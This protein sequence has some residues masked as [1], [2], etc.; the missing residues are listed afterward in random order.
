MLQSVQFHINL[1]LVLGLTLYALN[2]PITPTLVSLA[3]FLGLSCFGSILITACSLH[4]SQVSSDSIWQLRIGSF[5]AGGTFAILSWELSIAVGLAGYVGTGL[6]ILGT[7]SVSIARKKPTQRLLGDANEASFG[8]QEFVALTVLSLL[9]F[10]AAVPDLRSWL[11]PLAVVNMVARFL[12]RLANPAM[13]FALL[14]TVFVVR[15]ATTDPSILVFTDDSVWAEGFSA[16]VQQTGFWS[17]VGV[18]NVYS[19]LH[20]LAY[21]IA[22]WFTRATDDHFLFGV[23]MAFPATMSVVGALIISQ[24][25]TKECSRISFVAQI[26]T[27]VVGLQLIGSQSISADLGFVAVLAYAL[28]THRSHSMGA[29]S[30]FLLICIAIAKIQFVP[31]IVIVIIVSSLLHVRTVGTT[32]AI[33]NAAM[34]LGVVLVTSLL[35]LDIIPFSRIFGWETNV[36]WG[37]SKVRFRGSELTDMGS[38][39]DVLGTTFLSFVPAVVLVATY[40]LTVSSPRI[41]QIAVPLCVSSGS[42]LAVI[43]FEIENFEYFGWISGALSAFLLMLSILDGIETQKSQRLEVWLVGLLITAS[44]LSFVVTLPEIDTLLIL[45]RIQVFVAL[46]LVSVA[47]VVPFMDY[48]PLRRH[49]TLR[50]VLGVTGVALC[51]SPH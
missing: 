23:T 45:Q 32:I 43:F 4:R 20:W 26:L 28:L 39:H 37:T 30:Y 1:T 47:I 10:I 2:G 22:G 19:P 36:G 21:G 12:P 3:I 31:V 17:W 29:L 34:Q 49:Y 11:I 35:V 15:H 14:F 48:I 18:S 50:S 25:R 8:F 33:R 38:L 40:L 5:L 46:F 16:V 13:L 44:V 51:P 24:L 6:L 27:I 41:C 42:F 9:L 7:M